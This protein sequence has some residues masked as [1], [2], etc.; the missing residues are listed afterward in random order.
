MGKLKQ[1]AIIQERES[2][3]QVFFFLNA[4]WLFKTVN[5]FLVISYARYAYFK[6]L[7]YFSTECIYSPNAYRWVWLVS[8]FEPQEQLIHCLLA[9]I[10]HILL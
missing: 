9:V 10:K 4:E 6:K 7:D 2:E 3:V 1:S 5:Y 8:S